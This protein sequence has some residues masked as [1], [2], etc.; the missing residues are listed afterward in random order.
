[1]LVFNCWF[2]KT[3]SSGLH[4]DKNLDTVQ[5]VFRT[6]YYTVI[7]VTTVGYGDITPVT[8]GGLMVASVEA[9]LGL[10]WFGMLTS[11]IVKKVFR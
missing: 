2:W 6:I 10:V 11:I 5:G 1:M 3:G 8:A 7:T 4:I 9:L